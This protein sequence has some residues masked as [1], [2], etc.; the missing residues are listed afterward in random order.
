MAFL[1]KLFH[2][3]QVNNAFVSQTT[4]DYSHVSESEFFIGKL[5]SLFVAMMLSFQGWVLAFDQPVGV[6]YA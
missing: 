1:I 2:F 6:A 3:L 5:S 4:P